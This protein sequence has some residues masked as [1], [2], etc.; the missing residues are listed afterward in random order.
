MAFDDNHN[1]RLLY[2]LAGGQ[3]YRCRPTHVVPEAKF[4]ISYPKPLNQDFVLTTIP[5]HKK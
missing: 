2:N 3:P 1:L 4:K 5:Q